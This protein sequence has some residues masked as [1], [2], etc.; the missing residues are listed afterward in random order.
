MRRLLVALPLVGALALGLLFYFGLEKDN[1]QELRSA[2]LGKPAPAF[3]LPG[4]DP[5][6]ANLTQ[7]D[8]KTGKPVLINMFASW[9]APCRVE[10]P[11]LIELVEQ[12]GVT[13]YG[14]AYKD[15]PRATQR[16]LD[17]L[18]NPFAKIGLDRSGRT[19]IDWGVA[20]VPETFVVDGSGTV[21]FRQWGPITTRD[22][23]QRLLRILADA[24]KPAGGAG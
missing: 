24:A 11:F 7:A 19:G 2:L 21:I 5:A 3:D 1:P 4:L 10:H 18:G 15:D 16:F 9:C 17:E 6:Q 20:G 12:H 23:Q 14:I 22:Q 13:L 8:L